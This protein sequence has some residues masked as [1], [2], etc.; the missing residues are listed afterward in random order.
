MNS[1]LI[2]M[3]GVAVVEDTQVDI[4]ELNNRAMQCGFLVHPK[5][6]N[7]SVKAFIDEQTINYN[8]TFYKRWQDIKEK[9]RFELFIDQW[10]HYCSTYGTDYTEGQGYVPNSGAQTPDYKEY[11]M[12]MPIEAKELAIKCLS[13]IKSGIALKKTTME[14]CADFIIQQ[15]PKEDINIDEIKNR[16]AQVYLCERLNILPTDTLTLFRFIVYSTTKET[17]V[18]KNQKLC[19]SIKQSAQ[20]F[21]FNRL[22]DKQITGLSGIFYRFKPL[23]LAF[24]KHHPATIN[25]IRRLAKKHHRPM[26]QA[27]WTSV[28]SAKPKNEQLESRLQEIS[29]FKVV[30]LMQLLKERLLEISTVSETGT[31]RMYVIRNQKIFLRHYDRQDILQENKKW[32][33]EVYELLEQHLIKH[34]QTKACATIFPVDYK[35]TLPATEKMFVGNMPFG[36]SYPLQADSYIGL[37]WRNEWGTRDFDL[38]VVDLMGSKIGWNADYNIEGNAERPEIIYSGDMTN[39]DPEASEVVL[40][41]TNNDAKNFEG[42]VYIN[43]YNGKPQSRYKLF[44]GQEKIVS[45]QHNYMVDPNGIRLT[46]DMESDEKQEQVIGLIADGS[47]TLMSLNSQNARVSTDNP[48]LLQ[49]IKRK[50]HCFIDLKNILVKAG[51]HSVEQ[52]TKTDEEATQQE[53]L[54]LTRLDKATIISLLKE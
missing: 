52:L 20:P 41:K 28:L 26:P 47:I 11:R 2:K 48:S 13:V 30:A 51:F 17:L 21:D 10:I 31:D 27:F 18:I 24:K 38:S 6:C 4:A 45:L 8:A 3:F 49:C 32:Y 43:R 12:I 33:K 42:L 23:F 35:L 1:E 22:N 7:E 39:A 50:S 9:S 34:L 16:E 15:T 46:V 40:F 36:S 19:D 25:K 53:V 29:I 5:V 37:Y 54:D 14:A 44:F